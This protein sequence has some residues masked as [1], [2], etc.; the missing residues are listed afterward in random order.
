MPDTQVADDPEG[1][2]L[3]KAEIAATQ[4]GTPPVSTSVEL[5]P[6][7]STKKARSKSS[8][9]EGALTVTLPNNV[10]IMSIME[11]RVFPAED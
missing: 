10:V 9:G 6:A 11:V 4:T 7:R 5:S 2:K 3:S 1:Y 8:E